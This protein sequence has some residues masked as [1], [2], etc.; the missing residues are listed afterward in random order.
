MEYVSL[1]PQLSCHLE[2]NIDKCIYGQGK[3]KAFKEMYEWFLLHK[4]FVADPQA[5]TAAERTQAQDAFNSTNY[6]L[7]QHE[8][9]L[10][11]QLKVDYK[12]IMLP[13]LK[14]DH[15]IYF[16]PIN[17]CSFNKIYNYV[18][19]YRWRQK[20]VVLHLQFQKWMNQLNLR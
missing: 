3:F 12:I 17:S 4:K 11:T 13:L 16:M 18:F 1:F 6:W 19:C 5:G 2:K 15:Y 20:E 10:S 9:S 7:Q 8:R 14:K